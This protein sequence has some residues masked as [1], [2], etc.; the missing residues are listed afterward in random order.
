MPSGTARAKK[1]TVISAE[2][3]QEYVT[4]NQ[5]YNKAKSRREKLR[6]TILR[7]IHGGVP[8]DPNSPYRLFI[9]GVDKSCVDWR[10]LYED[11]LAEDYPEDWEE[12]VAQLEADNRRVE[13][14]LKFEANVPEALKIEGGE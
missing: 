12:R 6:E 14:H 2:E 7:K 8:C 5:I 3:I 11:R 1:K 4:V 13:E 9:L 10:Q